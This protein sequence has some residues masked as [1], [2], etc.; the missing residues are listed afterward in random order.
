MKQ[1][2]IDKALKGINH[3]TKAPQQREAVEPHKGTKKQNPL[4]TNK[5]KTLNTITMRRQL[6]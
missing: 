2:F 5:T 3:N 6:S 1:Q 4:S